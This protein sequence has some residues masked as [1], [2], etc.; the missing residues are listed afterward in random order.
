MNVANS[1]DPDRLFRI[2][3]L[4]EGKP[5]SIE[6]ILVKL[7]LDPNV[8]DNAHAVIAARDALRRR[9]PKTIASRVETVYGTGASVS[10]RYVGKDDEN[11]QHV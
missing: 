2:L 6:A 4:A 11:G 9:D 7:K 8:G 5:L 3:R 10:Y 1:V